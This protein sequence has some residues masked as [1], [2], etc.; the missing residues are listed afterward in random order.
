[1]NNTEKKKKFHLGK[2]IVQFITEKRLFIILLVVGLCAVSG[3]CFFNVATRE[4]VA[5]FSIDE[6]E[7]GMIADRNI[8]ADKSLPPDIDNPVAIEQGEKIIKKG[9]PITE[10]GFNKLK[11]IAESPIY[12]DYRAFANSILYLLLLAVIWC[13]LYASPTLGR[14]IEFKEALIEVIFFLLTYGLAIYGRKSP[15]FAA[16]YYLPIILPSAFCIFLVAI[17]FGQLSAYFFAF[18]LALGV[19]NAS[20]YDIIPALFT[21]VTSIAATRIVRNIYRR[22]DMV[23]VSLLLSVMNVVF[24][25]LVKV[26]FNSDLTELLPLFAGL[27]FNGF[28]SGILALGFLT[29]LELLLNTAS[30]FRLMDLSD[31]NNPLMRRMLLTASGT[32][33]HSMMVATLAEN[34]CRVI[35]ANP[36]VARVGAYYHDIGKMD[37]AEYFVE[38]QQTGINKHNDIN[39]SLSVSVIRSHV[40]KGVEK[41]VQMRL[42]K[43][44]VDIISEHHGNSLIAYFYGEAKKKDPS[45]APEDFS[46]T[47]TPPTTK[48]SAVV[49]LADTVEA[50]CRTLEN[51]TMPRLDKFIQQLLNGKVEHHQLDNC[52]L[53]F[54]D[55]TLIKESFVQL[56]GGYYHNRIEY[57]DQKDPDTVKSEKN[58]HADADKEEDTLGDKTMEEVRNNV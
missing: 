21:L 27:A 53:T 30:V 33:N 9:F 26:M 44:I 40:K 39:P 20:N 35:G 32:Y 17:L 22:I 18:L 7:I 12:M 36:L 2:I 4:T 25:V 38:N 10:E 47:G 15:V 37:Q 45:V 23:F 55:I 42:P 31:L 46:Y 14:T 3:L 49:M 24:V 51:P 8:I 48:E 34:A 50:A 28:I 1:M 11:K 5:S 54:R 16:S 57:P 19:F 58:D 6:F 41:A 29:P 52:P 56:L 43:Q 13:L